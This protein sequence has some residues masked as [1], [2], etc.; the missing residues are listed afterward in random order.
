[1]IELLHYQSGKH[2]FHSSRFKVRKIFFGCAWLF[3]WFEW[4]ASVGWTCCGGDQPFVI[5]TVFL[6]FVIDLNSTVLSND[7][8]PTYWKSTFRFARKNLSLQPH[9]FDIPMDNNRSAL[10]HRPTFFPITVQNRLLY[11]STSWCNCLAG[12]NEPEMLK[13]DGHCHPCSVRYGGACS[14]T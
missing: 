12:E 13:R 4:P 11:L 2:G 14:S 3:D 7:Q 9:T 10:D 8:S 5:S 6:L 1:M